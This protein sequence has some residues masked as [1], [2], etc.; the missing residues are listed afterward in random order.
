[1][2]QLDL[3]AVLGVVLGHGCILGSSLGAVRELF[4]SAVG[5][6]GVE[7]GE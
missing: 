1:M 6:L 5:S 2:T 7:H 4:V 3:G